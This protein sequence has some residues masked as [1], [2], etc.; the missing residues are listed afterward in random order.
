MTGKTIAIAV[1]AV[2]SFAVAQPTT[3]IFT[4]GDAGFNALTNNAALEQGVVETRIGNAAMNGAWEVGLWRFGAVGTPLDQDDRSITNAVAVPFTLNYDGGTTVTFTIGG[5]T[6]SDDIGPGG[7]TDIFIRARSRADTEVS[8]SDLQLDGVDLDLTSFASTGNVPAQYL[9]I[10]NS[11]SSF[12]AF[13]LTGSQTFSWTGNRP[14]QSQLAAQIK[15]TNVP[16]PGA[17]AV[18]MLGFGMAARHRR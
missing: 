16:T 2:A 10:E 13:E 3:T 5:S 1:G 12:G 8:F 4:G 9:R 18:A 6:V 11:G 7:F 14:S 15:L 17:A